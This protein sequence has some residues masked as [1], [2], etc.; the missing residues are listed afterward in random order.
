MSH[1]LLDGFHKFRNDTKNYAPNGKDGLL[2]TLVKN[3]QDPEYLIIGC[4]DSRVAP[5]VILNLSP[6]TC[7]SHRPMGAMIQPY[8]AE[9]N[10]SKEFNAK[11]K[12]ALEGN[13]VKEIIIMGHTHCGAI[14]ALVGKIDDQDISPWINTAKKALNSA[15][16]N[17][18]KNENNN[19]EEALL[20]ETEQ[21]AVI[22]SIKNLATYPSVQNALKN[23]T[24]KIN[25]WIFDMYSANLLELDPATG[26]FNSIID[27]TTSK[28]DD[29]LLDAH[30]QTIK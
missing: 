21:Q 2:Q 10:S 9:F 28:I 3:G 27:D 12:F 15:A 17:L 26:E 5:E 24:L 25:G 7:F 6:G 19:S 23:G 14:K 18:S 29:N 16:N 4:M 20:R 11:V 1:K 22:L 13:N 8:D 30:V